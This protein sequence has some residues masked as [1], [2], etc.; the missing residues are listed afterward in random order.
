MGQVERFPGGPAIPPASQGGVS[1]ETWWLHGVCA[2]SVVLWM[3][4]SWWVSV[5]VGGFLVGLLTAVEE[6]YDDGPD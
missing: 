1:R 4:G 5:V 3:P 6:W 2:A